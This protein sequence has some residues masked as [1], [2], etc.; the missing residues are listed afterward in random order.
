MCIRASDGEKLFLTTRDAGALVI[1]ADP[2]DRELAVNSIG[3]PEERFSATPT[4]VS[5]QILLRSDKILYCLAENA[6]T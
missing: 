4:I 2:V 1:A 6:G 5:G 3:S